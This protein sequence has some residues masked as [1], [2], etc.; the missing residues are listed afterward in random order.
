ML[1]FVLFFFKSNLVKILEVNKTLQPILKG[2]V[3]LMSPALR[4]QWLMKV[5]ENLRKC[6][7]QNQMVKYKSL[8]IN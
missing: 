5:F 7:S 6:I 1:C 4:E 2:E 3:N 8:A